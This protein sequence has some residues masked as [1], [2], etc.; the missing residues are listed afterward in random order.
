MSVEVAEK[1]IESP[2]CFDGTR[3]LET[4]PGV[5]L[6][7]GEG[8]DTNEDRYKKHLKNMRKALRKQQSLLFA[9]KQYSVLMIFQ[10]LDAAG[11]DGAIREVLQGLDPAGVRVAAFK[12]PSTTELS[13]DFL[14]RT[15]QE[16]PPRGVVTAFN[17]SYYE[18]VLAV[19][20]HPEFLDAQFPGGHPELASLWKERFA[21]I[22]AHERHLLASNTVV[23]K[24][25]LNVSPGRQARRFLDRLEDPRKHWKFSSRDVLES[26]LREHY[27]EALL[28][29]LRETSR[30]WA[31][32]YCIPADN[33][34]YLRA[35]I[36]D[37]LH[38]ALS[39]L[40]LSYPAEE[41][42]RGEELAQ[43]KDMLESRVKN[44]SAG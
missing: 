5:F 26:G 40:P 34:W 14:W 23:L 3:E 35:H 30:P 9:G 44:E 16:L 18:E 20:V 37:I 36:A 21:A 42:P 7:P 29:L 41:L 33:R 4:V 19:R 6:P 11:K 1:A 13:H 12:K 25:W 17:R 43:L 32:W 28:D 27:D 24:F 10:A 8:F 31:P 22:R 38:Q 15:S 39:R 2:W